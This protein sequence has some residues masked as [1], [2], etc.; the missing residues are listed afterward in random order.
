MKSNRSLRILLCIIGMVTFILVLVLYTGEKLRVKTEQDVEAEQIIMIYIKENNLG[1]ELGSEQYFQLMKGIL[2]GEHPDLT[3]GYSVYV[4]SD[5]ERQNILEYAAKQM[6]KLNKDRF[7]E[8]DIIE[9]RP[10]NT[11]P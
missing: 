1:I 9:A 4:K 3:S 5:Q 10:T 8:P 6:D 7:N 2:L 11:N